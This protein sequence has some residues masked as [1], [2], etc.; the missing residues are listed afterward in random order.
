MKDAQTYI[1]E[2]MNQNKVFL[3]VLKFVNPAFLV[4]H[5]ACEEISESNISSSPMSSKVA[6]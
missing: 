6:R 3:G 4:L 5:M 2:I 1:T